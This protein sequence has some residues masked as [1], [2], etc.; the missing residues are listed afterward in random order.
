MDLTTDSKTSE[1]SVEQP[2][3]GVLRLLDIDKSFPGV[4]TRVQATSTDALIASFGPTATV[5]NAAQQQPST[6]PAATTPAPAP[7]AVPA[8]VTVTAPPVPAP[9][10]GAAPKAKLLSTSCSART[11]V[12]T[13]TVRVTDP[14]P[15]SGVKGVQGTVTTSYKS[16]CKVKGK[17]KACTRTAAAKHLT[18]KAIAFD[19]YKI[20]TPRLRAGKQVFALYGI[21]VAGHRQAKATLVTKT[22]R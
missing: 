5:N 9:V 11:H 16:T 19:T 3:N 1:L 14:Q 20:T 10:D 4:Y 6:T 2:P 22:T 7:P 21:D 17:R 18:A 13:L 8:A 15:S 12:C